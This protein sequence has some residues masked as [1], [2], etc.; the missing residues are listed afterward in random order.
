MS[1]S[2]QKGFPAKC[3]YRNGKYDV[4]IIVSVVMLSVVA[5][6][7]LIKKHLAKATGLIGQ[8][9]ESFL[10]GTDLYD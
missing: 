2:L 10:K 4:G 1:L 6:Q 5:L 7:I 3:H 8:G 9:R